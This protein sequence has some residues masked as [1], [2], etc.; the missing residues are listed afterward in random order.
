MHEVFSVI[1]IVSCARDALKLRGFRRVGTMAKD[2]GR[3]LIAEEVD[4]LIYLF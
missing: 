4:D 2:D 3:E 1:V